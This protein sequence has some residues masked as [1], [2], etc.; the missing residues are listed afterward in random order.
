MEKLRARDQGAIK[1][2]F[3]RLLQDNELE[4]NFFSCVNKAMGNNNL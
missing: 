1:N 2:L 4:E 3:D